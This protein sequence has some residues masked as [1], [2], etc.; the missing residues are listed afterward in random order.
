MTVV[1]A[2]R[3]GGIY[4]YPV[5]RTVYILM[6]L[7]YLTTCLGFFAAVRSGIARASATEKMIKEK[8]LIAMNGIVKF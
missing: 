7:L 1:M 3:I 6:I 2:A 8:E 5:K 4:F